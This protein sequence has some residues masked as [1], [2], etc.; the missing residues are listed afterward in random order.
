MTTPRTFDLISV[1]EAAARLRMEPGSFGA[2]TLALAEAAGHVTAGVLRADRPFPPFD[3]VAMDGIAV[4]FAAGARRWRLSGIQAAGQAAGRLE[5][6]TQALEVMTGAVLPEGADTVIQ[7]EHLQVGDGQVELLPGIDPHPGQN[8]HRIASDRGKG[9]VVLPTGTMLTGPAIAIAASIGSVKIDVLR[10]PV[11]TVIATG[12]ELVSPEQEPLPHQI[13]ASNLEALCASLR[14]GGFTM[15]QGKLVRDE[16][17]RM[18]RIIEQ[19]LADSDIVVLSGGVSMGRFDHVPDL[20]AGLGLEL[21]FHGVRQ[22]PGKPLLAARQAGPSARLV[23]AL[24]GN[25]VSAVVALQRYLIPALREACGLPAGSVRVSLAAPF[26]FRPALSL[27]LP[28]TLQQE[29]SGC[30]LAMPLPTAGSGDLAA[31]AGTDG[32][33]ELESTLSDFPAGHPC[34]FYRWLP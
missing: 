20:L 25:P 23:L 28:V 9:E 18:H 27:F 12:S 10:R 13:R 21:L 11:I 22:R 14:L 7:V 16:P 8:V 15:V 32:F 33:V 6:S 3:R 34:P 30:L 24:P 17:S 4:R 31:L 29:P 2:T 1:A 5:D 19:A 26:D